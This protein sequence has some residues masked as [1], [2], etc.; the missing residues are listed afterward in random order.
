VIQKPHISILILA[1]TAA[2]TFA[3]KE[4]NTG[5]FRYDRG[6]VQI[7]GTPIEILSTDESQPAAPYSRLRFTGQRVTSDQSPAVEDVVIPI[8]ADPQCNE[9]VV[10][11]E[12]LP[13][14]SNA[15]DPGNQTPDD[16]AIVYVGSF[17]GRG[18]PC[19][20]AVVNSINNI[21]LALSHTGAHEIGH[22]V[23]LFHVAAFDDIMV[24]SPNLAFQ[25]ELAFGR[26]QIQLGPKAPGGTIFP[27][28]T[29]VIQDPSLYFSAV[30][31][32]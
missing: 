29:N 11:G 12:L 14:G 18:E 3:A 28:L 15:R 24:V 21:I 9:G 6:D 16:E 27:V 31:G 5:E 20:S 25:R 26:S 22:L 32:P 19:L 4:Q 30:F 2:S 8:T 7:T 10:F 13:A 17:Q 1:I 23:G